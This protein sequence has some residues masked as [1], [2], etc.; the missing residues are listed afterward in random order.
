MKTKKTAFT[1]I[2]LLVVI[3]IIAI[4]IGLLLPAVQKVREAAA[5]TKC[6]NNFKQLG[7]A[8]HNFEST[9]GALPW[10]QGQLSV[11]P[12]NTVNY[13][14]SGVLL[15]LPYLEQAALFAKIE[16]TDGD[17]DPWNGFV[18]QTQRIPGLL[19]PS[20]P[21]PIPD[22]NTTQQSNY[23][24][25]LGDSIDQIQFARERGMFIASQTAALSGVRTGLKW[26]D[27]SDGTSNTLAMSE[28]RRATSASAR[29]MTMTYAPQG[30]WFTTPNQCRASFDFANRSFP[31]SIP[32]GDLKTWSGVRWHDGGSGFTGISTNAAPNSSPACCYVAW[33]AGSGMYPPSSTHTG[34]VVA[35]FADAS[36]RFI[37]NNIDSGNQNATGTGLTGPS[38][39]GVFGAMGTRAG[40]EPISQ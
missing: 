23:M 18:N 34:G 4:L 13:R 15:L 24:F 16:A 12:A 7:L 8:I 3:A 29:D 38:P 5:R 10:H 17:K 26:K 33:D 9:M 31:A 22:T 6:T 27:I 28:R 30:N 2:E 37:T 19:C 11:V 14:Q 1:L 40:E 32:Q 25:C 20:D 36:V 21:A 35:V 39:F